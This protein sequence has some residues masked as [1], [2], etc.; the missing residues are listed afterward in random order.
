MV[1]S[2][3][4][5]WVWGI[6]AVRETVF[7]A[8]VVAKELRVITDVRHPEI[9]EIVEKARRSGVRV[10]ETNLP[11]LD[12]LTRR[13][14]HQGLAARVGP[15]PYVDLKGISA[16]AQGLIVALDCVQDPRNLGAILRTAEAAS[17]TGALL[18]TDRSAAVTPAV[19]RSA[20]G[21]VYRVPIARVTNL[22]RALETLKA[23]GWWAVGLAPR[24]GRM[25]YEVSLPARVVLVIGGEGKGIR[26]LVAR[27]CDEL[28]CLPM[29][30]GVNSLNAAVAAGVALYEIGPRRRHKKEGGQADGDGGWGQP[31]RGAGPHFG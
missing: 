2:A 23:A 5:V 10:C 28:V 27:S 29:A 18:P 4:D 8:P 12:V 9:R 31:G 19:V 13:G 1:P 24:Q 3:E 17:A 30:A 6:H 26:P 20:G 11:S 15:F 16:A 7:S 25:L 22:V 21:Y 14:K